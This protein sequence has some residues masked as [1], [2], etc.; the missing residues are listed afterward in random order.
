MEEIPFCILMSKPVLLTPCP[1]VEIGMQSLALE[2]S[3]ANSRGQQPRGR[4]FL[5]T[6]RWS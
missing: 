2:F 4:A 3:L 6:V 1:R 5:V